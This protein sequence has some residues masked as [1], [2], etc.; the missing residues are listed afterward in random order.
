MTTLREKGNTHNI[1]DNKKIN[2][3]SKQAKTNVNNLQKS[4]DKWKK[5]YEIK[6]N[7]KII[8]N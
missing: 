6:T 2:Q 4:E 5:M 7:L 1:I 8:N 3:F